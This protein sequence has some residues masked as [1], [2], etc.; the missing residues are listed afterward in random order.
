MTQFTSFVA[1]EESIVTEGGKPRRVEVPVEMPHG[2]S[3]E[4]VFGERQDMR[5]AK[6]AMPG[7]G[8]A[9]GGGVYRSARP[10]SPPPPL[11]NRPRTLRDERE[12]DTSKIDPV[13]VNQSRADANATLKVK[14][15]LDDDSPAV[16]EQLRKLSF[17]TTKRLP[18]KILLGEISAS[19]LKALAALKNVTYVS[20]DIGQP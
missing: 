12:A 9:M 18:G 8:G 1:V 4:G 10:L 5:M 16:L 14:I 20:R 17:R 11:M 7:S 2:V 15:W 13:L 6:V 19:K 3:Y